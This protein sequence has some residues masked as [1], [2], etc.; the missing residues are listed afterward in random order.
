ML[1]TALRVMAAQGE[2][3]LDE[4]WSYR[5]AQLAESP[6]AI[7]TALHNDNNHYLNTLYLRFVPEGTT[8][9]WTYRLPAIGLGSLT[10][11][12]AA[13]IARQRSAWAAL[14]AALFTATSFLL[15]VYSS[16]ARG[17]AIAVGFGFVCLFTL[18]RYLER[19]APVWGIVATVSATL[20]LLGH[21]TF[22]HALAGL[23]A[24][25]VVRDRREA[26]GRLLTDLAVLTVVPGITLALL[27]WFDLRD[28]QIGGGPLTSPGDIAA[29]ALALSVGGPDLGGWKAL[30]T[31]AAFLLAIA[32]IAAVHR[33]GSDLWV[34]FLV[35]VIVAPALTLMVVDTGVIY[36]RYLL[37]AAAYMTLSFAWL[38]DRIA[39]RTM[40][41]AGVIVVLFVAA[42]AVRTWQFIT[43][44]RSHYTDAMAVMLEQSSGSIT[45]VGSDHDFRNGRVV[46]FYQPL[47]PGGHGIRYEMQG[48]W[49]AGGP[50]WLLT[51]R[52]EPDFT[53]RTELTVPGGYRYRLVRAYPYPGVSG[54][55]LA[56]YRNARLP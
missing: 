32:S 5:L 35:T 31:L 23:A 56:L 16:E 17:Y 29:S 10:I 6:L 39:Y 26:R 52:I 37:V 11:L 7:F 46:E 49:S 43:T 24:Y 14:A 22:L 12:F 53:P 47:V 21:L 55:H 48:Q 40:V 45:S 54:W 3:W 13:L 41:G 27:Y 28:L 50:D 44:G 20:A 33:S 2:L 30:A 51:H 1:G 18:E 15:I 4:I 34:L 42:N 38:V 9:W 36:E 25:V 8:A 19:R